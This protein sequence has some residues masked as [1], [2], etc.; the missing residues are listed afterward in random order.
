MGTG[1][2]RGRT[3][4]FSGFLLSC[5]PRIFVQLSWYRVRAM[6]CKGYIAKE[7][8]I[9]RSSSHVFDRIGEL[10]SYTAHLG[11]ICSN[12]VF[13]LH[14][15]R[16]HQRPVTYTRIC[17]DYET[18]REASPVATIWAD[19]NAALLPREIKTCTPNNDTT[20][21]TITKFNPQSFPHSKS[22][23]IPLAPPPSFA[24]PPPSPG[25]GRTLYPRGA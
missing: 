6:T 22:P 11:N 8:A 23:S 5:L 17:N 14:L 1:V 20:I 3:S 9:F 7:H 2:W 16:A 12:H 4:R 10:E 13:P 19:S 24:P 18:N 21:Q 15:E 25:R